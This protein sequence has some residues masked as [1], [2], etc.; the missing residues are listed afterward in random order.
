MKRK[1]LVALHKSKLQQEGAKQR[2]K[3]VEKE[4]KALLK[5]G[6]WKLVRGDK[7]YYY[8]PKNKEERVNDL[9][10]KVA[11]DLGYAPVKEKSDKDRKDKDKDKEK[12][13]DKDKDRK[14]KD[15]DK[16]KDAKKS[17]KADEE[18]AAADP[19][20]KK[21]K[22]EKRKEK[23]KA[24]AKAKAKE[25]S[26]AAAAAAKEDNTPSSPPPD[27]SPSGAGDADAD[28]SLD[29]LPPPPVKM[30]PPTPQAAAA[31]PVPAAPARAASVASV[32]SS[33]SPP[34][35][36]NAAAAAAAAAAEADR[37]QKESLEALLRQQQEE[38]VARE[39]AAARQAV[40]E[41]EAYV[42]VY[43]VAFSEEVDRTVSREEH[44]RV[45]LQCEMAAMLEERRAGLQRSALS[46]MQTQQRA[47][48]ALDERYDRDGLRA[49]AT[50]SFG[51]YYKLQLERWLHERALMGEIEAEDRACHLSD[52][53]LC[54]DALSIVERRHAVWANEVASLVAAWVEFTRTKFGE[55]F[56][57]GARELVAL[58]EVEQAELATVRLRADA[59]RDCLA[60]EG[61]ARRQI[62][63]EFQGRL[64]DETEA[65]RGLVAAGRRREREIDRM[66][67]HS[68][69]KH[70]ALIRAQ[71]QELKLRGRQQQ[72]GAAEAAPAPP[73]PTPTQQQMRST[74]AASPASSAASPG[75]AERLQRLQDSS[76]ECELARIA[77]RVKLLEDDSLQHRKSLS[78]MR[79]ARSGGGGKGGARPISA[80]RDPHLSL[81]PL[82]LQVESLRALQAHHTLATSQPPNPDVY[83]QI[84]VSFYTRHDPQKIAN[85]P[86]LLQQFKGNEAALFQGLTAK[87]RIPTN[88]AYR[89]SLQSIMAR[90]VP[91]QL[92]CID[93]ILHLYAG[94]EYE[95]IEHLM[96]TYNLK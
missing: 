92:P 14:D 73:S 2:E 21:E 75:R 54:R 49:A 24:K 5:E 66:P 27:D 88:N 48:L 19:D 46:A 28:D 34:G 93:V 43:A 60:C 12:G 13:K 36:P 8:M 87:Y 59:V 18:A 53:E 50:E 3:N 77:A 63:L 47:E 11:K 31:P 30:K 58:K 69:E 72:V 67:A 56:L 71:I 4:V 82:R 74:T 68:S 29:D 61:M 89:D 20:K 23:E 1:D 94:T 96:R 76:R 17:R 39:T 91:W 62:E 41:E 6:V 86:A 95:L 85:V 25:D 57:D 79:S 22:E 70:L 64:D 83:R 51:L 42:R 65:F 40:E 80:S 10:K 37:A 44:Q 55:F 78:D 9:H 35:S 52:E 45:R 33:R 90:A 81:E 16:E 32:A 84:L 7:P 38:A 26:K 15:K